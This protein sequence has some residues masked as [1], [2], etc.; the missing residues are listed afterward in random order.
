MAVALVAAGCAGGANTPYPV[1]GTVFL[2]GQPA[3]E[4]AGWTVT[5]TSAELH[6][7]ASGEIQADG[8]YRLGTWKKDD[9][10]FP[11]TYQVS[12]S[13]PESAGA[14][15]RGNNRPATPKPAS[16]VAP[17]NLE[18]VVAQTTNDIPI[19]LQ[20]STKPSR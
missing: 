20:R 10:A 6:K 15:E 19:Q 2:D 14:S 12:V 9:G 17:A 11:G 8:T 5:F 13:P 18:V 1:H 3:A 4:L 16:V 7:S